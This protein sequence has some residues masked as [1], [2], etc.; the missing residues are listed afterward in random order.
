[1][2]VTDGWYSVKATLDAPLAALLRSGRLRIG[3]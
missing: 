1:M 2:E 3:G